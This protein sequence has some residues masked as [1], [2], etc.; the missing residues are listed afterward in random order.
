MGRQASLLE[1][2]TVL[3]KLM[4]TENLTVVHEPIRTAFFDLNNRTLHCPIWEDMTS[5]IYDLLMG[6]EVSHALHTPKQGWHDSITAEGMKFKTFIN[7]CEDARIEK[8]IK[9]KYPG[10]KFSFVEAYAELYKRDLFGINKLKDL[11]KLNLIDRINIYFKLGAHIHVVFTETEQKW[12]DELDEA[13]TFEDALRVAKA[14]FKYCKEKEQNK[15]NDI[16]DLMTAIDQE[17]NEDKQ[18]QTSREQKEQPKDKAEKQEKTE[19]SENDSSES[20]TDEQDEDGDETEESS[21][22][23]EESEDGDTEEGDEDSEGEGSSESDDEDDADSDDK[24]SDSG[25]A[26]ANEGKD[27]QSDSDKPKEFKEPESVTDH[28]FRD[29]EKELVDTSS[30]HYV[31]NVTLPS[32]ILQNIIRK[33]TDMV[34]TFEAVWTSH[35]QA[36]TSY[37]DVVLN[38]NDMARDTVGFYTKKNKAYVDLLFKEFNMKKNAT[39]YARARTHRSGELDTRKLAQY[40]S[41]NDIFRR[42]T[43]V[44]Q[45]KS[46]GLVMF[47]DMSGSMVGINMYTAM[48]QTLILALFC[49]KAQIPYDVYGVADHDAYDTKRQFSSAPRDIVVRDSLQLRHLISSRDPLRV[50]KRSMKMIA[51]YTATQYLAYD[52]RIKIPADL[53]PLRDIFKDLPVRGAG[54]DGMSFTGTPLNRAILASRAI[55]DKFKADTKVDITNVIYL[56]DGDG[57]DHL[58]VPDK[59]TNRA[60]IL[61][62]VVVTDPITRKQALWP[63]IHDIQ[64]ELLAFIKEVTGCRHIGF[65]ICTTAQARARTQDIDVPVADIT[66]NLNSIK[67]YGFFAKP[68]LGFDNYYFITTKFMGYEE[69]VLDGDT[70]SLNKMGKLFSDNQRAKKASRIVLGNL[71]KEIATYNENHA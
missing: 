58:N 59:Q 67:D 50:Q 35:I 55:I 69:Q 48:E 32:P 51:M 3:A 8:L 7:V 63:R 14:V 54:N 37:H 49:N 65:Y 41:T 40:H 22:T 56:T 15:V 43:E 10:L 13:K 29:R 19:S 53:V 20:Q 46:H 12:V 71:A 21:E 11:S 62:G 17:K 64:S 9:R 31:A 1:A 36:H 27:N 45:G 52:E 28:V 2:K 16:S 23:D 33:T 61:T 42:I 68:H 66:K 4:A 60:R 24:K 34:D 30:E 44:T 39:Q 70:D 25:E 38:Y 47:I 57:T 6:H 18:K 5:A 26:D